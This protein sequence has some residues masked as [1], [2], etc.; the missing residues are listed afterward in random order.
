MITGT[1]V[2]AFFVLMVAV[3]GFFALMMHDLYKASATGIVRGPKGRF[4]KVRG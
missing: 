3:F 4:V 1:Q 2:V